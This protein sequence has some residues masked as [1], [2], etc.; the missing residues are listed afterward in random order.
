MKYIYIAFGFIFFALGAIGTT[1]PILPTVPFLLLASACFAKGSDRINHWFHNTTFYKNHLEEF[2]RTC[3]D[4]EK[5]TFYHDSRWYYS[6]VLFL[7]YGEHLWQNDHSC[8]SYH[9]I[10]CIPL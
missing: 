6:D 10:L 5:Q 2:E 4:H 9:Q 8:S 3:Y 1:I 7:S